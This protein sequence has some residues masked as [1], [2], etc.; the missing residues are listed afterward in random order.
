MSRSNRRA[1]A[2]RGQTGTPNARN[3]T[4]PIATND[5]AA[6]RIKLDDLSLKSSTVGIH[7]ARA[8]SEGGDAMSNPAE[9]LLSRLGGVS[10]RSP[11]RWFARCPSHDDGRPSLSVQEA[12][13][14]KALVQCFVGTQLQAAIDGYR[15]SILGV[16]S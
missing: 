11:G 9:T 3:G 5:G 7:M 1:T 14:Q 12:T 15:H 2:S 8:G 6:H 4:A 10:Q 13:D 16:R